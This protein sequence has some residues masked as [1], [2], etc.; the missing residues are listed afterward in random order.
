MNDIK[1]LKTIWKELANEQSPGIVKRAVELSSCLKTFCTY[2]SQDN[3]CGIA[4]S[5][6]KDI[7]VN[8]LSFQDLAEIKVSLLT[9][10]SFPDSNLLLIQL[11]EKEGRVIEIFETICS[12][13][14]AVTK[15]VDDERSAINLVIT[16]MKKWKQLFSRK[17]SE[18]LT[19]AEQQGL[20]GELFFLNKLLNLGFDN[21]LMTEY[22][23]GPLGEPQDFQAP[24]WSVEV[25]TVGLKNQNAVIINGEQ[26]LDESTTEKLFLYK[27][28]I[29]E[30]NIEGITLPGLV[31]EIRDR[32]NQDNY[33]IMDLNQKLLGVGYYSSDEELYINRHYLIHNE[34]YYHVQ[35]E[36]P[37]V[38]E[39]E[40]RLGVSGIKYSINTQDCVEYLLSEDELLNTIQQYE[41]D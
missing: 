30:N 31:E 32:L 7:N 17:S 26:Q 36:F 16:Q 8:I 35:G 5:F 38:K 27:L 23:V 9:D 21:A 28:I 3:N 19:P 37:R 10:N 25:K 2:N 14:M 40:L 1:K 6:H 20:L 29:E 13:I 39:K 12:N 15:R 11:V 22:W 4:F 34:K 18:A 33:A 24:R 41:R